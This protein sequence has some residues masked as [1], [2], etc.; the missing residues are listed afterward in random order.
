MY[1][2]FEFR[3]LEAGGVMKCWVIIPAKEKSEKTWPK[4]RE[5]NFQ[6]PKLEASI[7]VIT[8]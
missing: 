4:T 2:S 3:E 7:E 8:A 5:R 1:F 6:R